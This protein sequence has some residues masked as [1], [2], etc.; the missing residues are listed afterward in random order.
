MQDSLKVTN[1]KK[2][3]AIAEKKLYKWV[4]VIKMIVKLL[5]GDVLT[6]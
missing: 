5:F 4:F 2:S 1:E 6:Q 3:V